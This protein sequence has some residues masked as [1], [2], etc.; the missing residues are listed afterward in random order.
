MKIKLQAY[1]FFSI[2]TGLRFVETCFVIVMWA[3]GVNTL[4]HTAWITMNVK[5][6]F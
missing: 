2:F 6:D 3:C 1:E 4:Q 5:V